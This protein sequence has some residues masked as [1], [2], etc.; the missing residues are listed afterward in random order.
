M[1][2]CAGCLLVLCLLGVGVF[3]LGSFWVSSTPTATTSATNI[4]PPY[5]PGLN[6]VDLYLNLEKRGFQKEVIQ[7]DDGL[8]TW[9]LSKPLP[10][11]RKLTATC[12][13]FSERIQSLTAWAESTDTDGESFIRYVASMPYDTQDDAKLQQWITDNLATR[14]Q[15][16]T[17]TVGDATFTL[18]GTD[19]VIG[20]RADATR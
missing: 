5:I 10:G 17:I 13:G 18:M 11:Q 15:K 3:V 6:Q 1:K 8:T 14:D 2:N 19:F 7:G 20:I 4:R 9:K 16:P 12:Y